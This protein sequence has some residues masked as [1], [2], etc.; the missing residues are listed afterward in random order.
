MGKSD[1]EEE[2]SGGEPDVVV[3]ETIVAVAEE[4]AGEERSV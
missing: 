1:R 2:V 3:E 4:R